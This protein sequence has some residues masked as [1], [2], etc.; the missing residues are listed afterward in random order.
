[1]F[2]FSPEL[3]SS[4]SGYFH[5][6]W[7]GR[8]GVALAQHP[9]A[10]CGPECGLQGGSF[11]C[12]CQH[13]PNRTL[14]P[15]SQL[16]P[17]PRHWGRPWCGGYR[18]QRLS[19]VGGRH[20]GAG[21]AWGRGRAQGPRGTALPPGVPAGLPQS[22]DGAEEGQLRCPDREQ[23]AGKTGWYVRGD[24]SW[25]QKRMP[26]WMGLEGTVLSGRSQGG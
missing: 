26:R 11:A 17:G 3:C 10:G 23:R 19:T 18:Q 15:R 14:V 4:S 2:T 13:P 12:G 1:M 24:V 16:S 7:R 5:T 6:H 22:G 25:P 20:R 21:A 9:S 8:T